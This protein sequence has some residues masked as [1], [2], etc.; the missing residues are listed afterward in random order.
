MVT[1]THSVSL[2]IA[3]TKIRAAMGTVSADD[4]SVTFDIAKQNQIFAEHTDKRRLGFEMR[5]YTDG[6]PVTPQKLAHGRAA[7]S[8]GQDFIFF[9]ASLVHRN[10]SNL[11]KLL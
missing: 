4:A 10:A 5:R 6:P 9:F 2:Y 1:A 11:V 7:A 3:E 8:P